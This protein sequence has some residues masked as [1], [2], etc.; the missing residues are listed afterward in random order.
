LSAHPSP[1][2]DLAV[3]GWRLLLR[4]QFDELL[5]LNQL[6]HLKRLDYQIETV[7]KVLRRFRGRAMLSDEVGL[8]KTI[9]A[10]MIILE[11]TLRGLTQQTLILAPAA[12]VGQWREEL[13][14]KFGIIAHTTQDPA[15]RSDPAA[16]WSG[17]GVKPPRVVIA[18]LQLARHKQHA[19]HVQAQRWDL[20]VVDEAHHIKNR[21]TA[22][23]K[24]IDTLRSRFLLL[25]TATP[26]ENSLE[27][28]YNLVT[29]L[30]PGQL[31]T[32]TAFK[33]AFLDPDD[34]FSPRN[35]ERLRDLLA[36]VMI[37]NTRALAGLGAMLPPRFAQT[38]HIAPTPPEAA[39]YAALVQTIRTLSG[40]AAQG[41]ATPQR[42]K[43]RV[44]LRLLLEQAGSS[45]YALRASLHRRAARAAALDP[46][47]ADA[48]DAADVLAPAIRARLADLAGEALSQPPSKLTHLIALLRGLKPEDKALIFTKY[49]ASLDAIEDTLA[50]AAIP[51]ALFHG[52]MSATDKDAAV[53]RFRDDL[54]VLVATEVGGEGRNMQFANILINFDLPWNPTKIEQRI[55]RLHR[56][57][58]TR[59]VL[60]YN[61]CALGSAEE[62]ILDVLGG[63]IQLFELVVGEVD[64][65]LGK[66]LEDE[67]FEERVFRI[68]EASA[69]DDQVAAGFE[70]LA[71]EIVSA[72][73]QYNHVKALDAALFGRDF[74]A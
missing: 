63:R 41:G 17:Q 40:V 65:I 5:C 42:G 50:R 71:D 61:L 20:V 22:G 47:A 67:A 55:G 44:A 3:M 73:Q 37:R 13:A 62:R 72:K 48:A 32:L 64:M 30:K 7:S 24:L 69:D 53:A 9:E 38:V 4:E 11:F 19:A 39:L 25:L 34:P 60:I 43:Q 29:L 45:I 57:G 31:S 35:R 21:D 68:Y 74:E 23:Y 51:C 56:I 18:S 2:L 14:D 52:Q 59:E 27:E 6:K 70:S 1:A 10:G 66:A 36:E 26:V 16:A 46:D 58:Q 33:R 28:L 12:L 8:G 49:T 15:W 54:P